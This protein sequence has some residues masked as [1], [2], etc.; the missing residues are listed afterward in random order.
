MVEI[1]KT[2]GSYAYVAPPGLNANQK[3]L[4]EAADIAGRARPAPPVAF[5]IQARELEQFGGNLANLIQPLGESER[6]RGFA[7]VDALS[8]SQVAAYQ[9]AA[10]RLRQ[11]AAYF[12]QLRRDVVS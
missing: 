6:N 8:L 3:A 12:S 1:S 4:N 11:S 7:D 2:P 5:G 10:A 9:T